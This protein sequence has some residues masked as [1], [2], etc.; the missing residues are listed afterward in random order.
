ML[1]NA[2][3]PRESPAPGSC[4][5]VLC[6]VAGDL[7]G[8]HTSA[9]THAAGDTV[10]VPNGR[11]GAC[12]DCSSTPVRN[13]KHA[14][15]NP[16]ARQHLFEW[17]AQPLHTESTEVAKAELRRRGGVPAYDVAVS[18]VVVVEGLKSWHELA[19]SGQ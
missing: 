4:G 3:S 16:T 5:P 19:V 7:L 18:A 13:C 10:Y 17:P 1:P 12:N 11:C 2:D 8:V 14:S 6:T 9:G 15:A